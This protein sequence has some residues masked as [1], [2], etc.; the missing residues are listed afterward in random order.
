MKQFCSIH[1]YYYNSSVCPFCEQERIEA[2]AHRYVKVLAEK[3]NKD[4]E[5]S[6]DDLN[7]LIN[8][9]NRK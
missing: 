2:L 6:Q 7:K 1:H 4:R 9:F 8:K 3:K 5:V